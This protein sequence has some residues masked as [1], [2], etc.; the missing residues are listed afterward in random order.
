M[1]ADTRVLAAASTC[2]CT[3]ENIAFDQRHGQ[4]ERL[5]VAVVGRGKD[6]V[7]GACFPSSFRPDCLYHQTVSV[8]ARS[9]RCG[10]P[11]RVMLTCSETARAK[12]DTVS[13]CVCGVVT[14]GQLPK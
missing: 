8:I 9:R 3:L 14:H 10:Q 13:V 2:V 5:R 6:Q 12:V 7:P 1:I 11:R 4:L